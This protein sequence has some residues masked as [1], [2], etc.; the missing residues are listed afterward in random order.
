LTLDEVV[1][2]TFIFFIAGYDTT[3]N[4]LSFFAY[5]LAMNPECQ[6]KCIEEVDRVLGEDKPNYD[7]VLKLQ[8]L[9]NCLN[10]TLRMYAPA[11][12][13]NRH[14]EEECNIGGYRVPKGAGINI[15]IYAIHHDPEYWPEPYKFNPDR[16]SPGEKEK[17]HPYA[18]LPFG[19]GPRNCIGMRL[20]QLE[21][22][23]AMASVLQKYRF[24]RCT[25]TEVNMKQSCISYKLLNC[26]V[27]R[28]TLIQYVLLFSQ[29]TLQYKSEFVLDFK[30][31]FNIVLFYL[32]Y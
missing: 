31:I 12:V 32:I 23:A 4:T 17:H 27:H 16:F 10:E 9:D 19:H 7:N 2:N 1:A 3:A 6:D 20:A 8:Y 15:C 25:E 11:A 26:S 21:A 22:K 28:C 29:N 18:F 5:N 14:V 13:T 30:P 24:V